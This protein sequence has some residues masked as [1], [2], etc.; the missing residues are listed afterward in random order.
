MVKRIKKSIYQKKVLVEML[1]NPEKHLQE[2]N[3]KNFWC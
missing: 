2:K 3:W 1:S